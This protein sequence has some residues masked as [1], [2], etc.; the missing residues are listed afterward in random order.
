MSI[1]N[2]LFNQLIMYQA[3]FKNTIAGSLR[4]LNQNFSLE[5]VFIILGVSFL[6]GVIH[7][8]G[9]GHGKSI[10]SSYLLYNKSKYQRALK[11]GF[12]ISA[13]H[14]L[15]GL[16]VT[17]IMYYAL[18]M[19]VTR[20]FQKP[21]D[22]M[23]KISGIFIILSGFYLLYET[24]KKRKVKEEENIDFKKKDWILAFSAGFVPCPGVMSL[25]FFS[26]LLNKI[27]IGILAAV[28]MSLG[29]GLTISAIGYLTI[30]AR[31]RSLLQKN[32]TGLILNYFSIVLI[33]ILGL[34]L[35][36]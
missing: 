23:L 33:M 24:L 8:L 35:I 9:P 28:L 30:Y 5:I 13:I 22:I 7:S 12:M 31:N 4:E 6:Y 20:N 25:L 29:M 15:S 32:K 19:V 1:F 14:A 10:I 34:F 2:K 16:L 11:L 36:L 18:N 21:Y 17:A 26:I 3:E 27:W